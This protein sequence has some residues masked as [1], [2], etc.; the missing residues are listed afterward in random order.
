VLND[1]AMQALGSYDGGRMPFL[2]L[3]TSVGPTLIAEKAVVPLELGQLPF[4]DG[5]LADYLGREGLRRLRQA[6]WQKTLGQ[7]VSALKGRSWPTTWSSA[8]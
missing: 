7:A 8:A 2:G 6:E 4:R 1:A 3:G 5:C